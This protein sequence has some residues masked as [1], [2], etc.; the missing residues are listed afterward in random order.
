M[1][2]QV[3]TWRLVNGYRHECIQALVAFNRE[4]RDLGA[5]A[6]CYLSHDTMG[7]ADG[8]IISLT[9]VDP[10]MKYTGSRK[11]SKRQL[12]QGALGSQARRSTDIGTIVPRTQT[13]R[14]LGD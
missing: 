13:K 2:K 5:P 4:C 9:G 11:G 10:Q 14:A 8:V 12:A 1:V 6:I 7:V 3:L